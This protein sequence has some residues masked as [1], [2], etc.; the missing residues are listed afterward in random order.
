MYD[1]ISIVLSLYISFCSHTS[2]EFVA[3]TTTEDGENKVTIKSILK[4]IW[5]D[6]L[7]KGPPFAIR[8]ARNFAQVPDNKPVA[9]PS[10][11]V[12]FLASTGR[13]HVDLRQI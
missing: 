2:A 10:L 7:W 11:D 12:K 8:G 3:A 5:V 13:K 6:G 9:S 1:P 4:F